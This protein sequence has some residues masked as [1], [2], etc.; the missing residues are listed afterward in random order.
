[1]VQSFLLSRVSCSRYFCVIPF[2]FQYIFYNFAPM[3]MAYL[4]AACMDIV[5]IYKRRYAFL[6]IR[7]LGNFKIKH[8]GSI[9]VL[10]SWRG[11]LSLHLCLRFS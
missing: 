3:Y 8:R 2:V 6:L 11:L 10:T 9:V 7:N 1:M 5:G 4:Y